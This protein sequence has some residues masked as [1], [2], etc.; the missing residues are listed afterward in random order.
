MNIFNFLGCCV[1]SASKENIVINL[2]STNSLV[3]LLNPLNCHLSGSFCIFRIRKL[4]TN[5]AKS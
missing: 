2:I 1:C 4:K 5:P 3:A